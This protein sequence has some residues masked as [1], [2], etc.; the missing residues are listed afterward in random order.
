[1]SPFLSSQLSNDICSRLKNQGALKHSPLELEAVSA[2]CRRSLS[3]QADHL[4]RV[5]FQPHRAVAQEERVFRT[6]AEERTQGRKIF[7]RNPDSE[8]DEKVGHGQ[9]LADQ[10]RKRRRRLHYS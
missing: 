10:R 7:A 8:E 1:M 3:D 9:V 6:E 2:Q 5:L 4:K